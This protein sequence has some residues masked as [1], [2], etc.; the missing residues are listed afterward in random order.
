MRLVVVSLALFVLGASAAGGAQAPKALDTVNAQLTKL[1]QQ[2]QEAVVAGDIQFITT[3]TAD[4]F[5]FTHG[6]GTRGDSKADWI[7]RTTQVPRPYLERTV[8]AQSVEVHGDAAMVFG[9]LDVRAPGPTDATPRCYAVQYAHLYALRDG[10]WVF[11]S[12]R[13]TQSLEVSHPCPQKQSK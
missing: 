5:L 13:T 10:H 8:S 9:R 3:R 7:R 12:H 4:D 1:D 6:S 2:W 11:V